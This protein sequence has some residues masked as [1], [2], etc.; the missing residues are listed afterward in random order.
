M[1]RDSKTVGLLFNF[2]H[3]WARGQ[4]SDLQQSVDVNQATQNN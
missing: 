2:I 4:K 1:G 3:L